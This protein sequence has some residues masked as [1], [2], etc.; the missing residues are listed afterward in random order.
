MHFYQESVKT[1]IESFRQLKSK[2]AI[3]KKFQ[4]LIYCIIY[5]ISKLS[6]TVKLNIEF[7]EICK[8]LQLRSNDKTNFW[9][10]EWII[11]IHIF[12]IPGI[13]LFPITYYACFYV[14]TL[15]GHFEIR[16]FLNSDWNHFS[17]YWN[18]IDK[19]LFI[20]QETFWGIYKKCNV[21]ILTFYLILLNSIDIL[22][23]LYLDHL[24]Y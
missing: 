16:F 7:Q 14:T 9:N 15:D 3:Y 19:K 11:T 24:V 6:T 21:I 4:E 8:A 17:R 22:F 13:F 10:I 2:T 18:G 1:F 5:C 20:Y 23:K 12:K